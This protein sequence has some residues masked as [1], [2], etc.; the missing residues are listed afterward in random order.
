MF[1]FIYLEKCSKNHINDSF[2]NYSAP[3]G[4]QETNVSYSKKL[5]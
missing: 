1:V 2:R 4:P 5:E 3:S